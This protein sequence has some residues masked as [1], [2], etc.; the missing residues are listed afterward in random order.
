MSVTLFDYM[1]FGVILTECS[2]V[3]KCLAHIKVN[4]FLLNNWSSN[5][6]SYE[7]VDRKCQNLYVYHLP[8]SSKEILKCLHEL[9]YEIPIYMFLYE[10]IALC[11]L[12]GA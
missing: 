12:K 9:V 3:F 7:K 6:T 10:L 2:E 4:Q 1:T 11:G 5:T 8:L